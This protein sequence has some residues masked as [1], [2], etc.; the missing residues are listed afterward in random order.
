VTESQLALDGNYDRVCC[1][2][3]VGTEGTSYETFGL[4]LL[5][6]DVPSD[7]AVLTDAILSFYDEVKRAPS[8][9]NVL[10]RSRKGRKGKPPRFRAKSFREAVLDPETMRVWVHVTDWVHATGENFDEHT[11]Q[12]FLRPRDPAKQ[13]FETRW[14]TLTATV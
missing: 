11:F 7:Y 12:C 4:S 13:E 9:F 2:K 3:H 1:L 8:W 5:A 14:V 6:S 10:Y